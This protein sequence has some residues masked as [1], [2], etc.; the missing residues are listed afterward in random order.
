MR[1]RFKPSNSTGRMNPQTRTR[2]VREAVKSIQRRAQ[3]GVKPTPETL[4]EV[5]L[6][7]GVT[8]EEL[9]N[10]LKPKK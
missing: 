7:F 5:A 10:H 8:P 2:Q 4:R 1:K 3:M 9:L 6:K